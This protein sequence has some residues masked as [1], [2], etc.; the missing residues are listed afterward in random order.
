MDLS[1]QLNHV[2]EST[3]DDDI[4]ITGITKGYFP[5]V[6]SNSIADGNSIRKVTVE[7]MPLEQAPGGTMMA[8]TG[9]YKRK[10]SETAVEVTLMQDGKE[11]AS[12]TTSY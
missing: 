2:N 12:N 5:A 10:D 6:T 8:N 7:L 3:Y 1:Q 9:L 11:V 4:S